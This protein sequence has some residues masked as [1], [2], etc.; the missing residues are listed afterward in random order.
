[1]QEI[2]KTS[3]EKI[4]WSLYMPWELG[5][6]ALESTGRHVDV[7]NVIWIGTS[8][9][10]HD[11][12]F[13]HQETRRNP[14]EMMSREDYLDVM[15]LLRSKVSERLGVRWMQLLSENS[16]TTYYPGFR[17]IKSHYCPSFRAI[18]I[19]GKEGHLCRST[20]PPR[21]R[22]LPTT[23]VHI[24]DIADR[25]C[26]CRVLSG[27]GRSITSSVD[28]KSITGYSLLIITTSILCFVRVWK[29]SSNPCSL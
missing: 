17:S 26:Y 8:N 28:F 18:H 14:D 21:R 20:G 19:R 24:D 6:Y 7:R 22:C 9:I 23:R 25:F 1:M 29:L 10:G 3:N 27:G 5:R 2:E 4:L 13:D 16:L 15:T 11:L 12:I